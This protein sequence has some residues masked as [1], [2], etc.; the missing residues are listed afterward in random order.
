MLLTA[1]HG[2]EPASILMAPGT[3]QDGRVL[4]LHH[5]GK[6]QRIRLAGLLDSGANFERAGYTAA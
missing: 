3:W 6:P 5:D 4:D 2:G 1:A